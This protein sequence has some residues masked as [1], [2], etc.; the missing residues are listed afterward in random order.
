MGPDDRA[1]AL[2]GRCRLPGQ[3]H[4][5]GDL[6]AQ[7]LDPFREDEGA[8]AH[9]S[10]EQTREQ[11]PIRGHDISHSR[12]I[13]GVAMIDDTALAFRSRHAHLMADQ[14]RQK[15]GSGLSVSLEAP[16]FPPSAAAAVY[17]DDPQAVLRVMGDAA[18]MAPSCGDQEALPRQTRQFHLEPLPTM[19]AEP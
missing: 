8:F 6:P 5:A 17:L 10:P 1:R 3:S 11:G 2:H 9:L 16:A 12:Q 14:M 18:E 15:L 4:A 13:S 19:G 7:E